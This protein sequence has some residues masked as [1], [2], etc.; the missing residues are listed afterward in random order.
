[1]VGHTGDLKAGIK[2]VEFLDLCIKKILDACLAA[3]AILLITADH[4]NVEQMINQKTGDIDKDHTTNPVPFLLAAK[5]LQFPK[6]KQLLYINLAREVPGGVISD[7]APTIL[8]L[9]EL[10]KPPDMT[11]VNLFEEFFSENDP[12]LDV[13]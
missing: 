6:P 8:D 11:G 7:I 13:K 1:M 5:E 3:D 9:F 12:V 10:P 4:G 2:A